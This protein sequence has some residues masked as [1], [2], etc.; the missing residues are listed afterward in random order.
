MKTLSNISIL[1]LTVIALTVSACTGPSSG[2]SA[3]APNTAQGAG[4]IE[5]PELAI[6]PFVGTLILNAEV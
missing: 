5:M 1:S 3:A 2:S 4:P 6:G